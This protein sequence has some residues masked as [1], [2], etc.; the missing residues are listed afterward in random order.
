MRPGGTGDD[1]LL[2]EIVVGFPSMV[3]L[4]EQMRVSFFGSDAG[5]SGETHTAEVKLTVREAGEGVEVPMDLPVRPTCPVC[6]GRGEVWP[7]TCGMCAGTGGG[8]L[9]HQFQL[10]VPAGVRHGTRLTYC[11]TPP[12]ASETQLEVRIAIS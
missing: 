12:F 4:V 3:G 8:L 9:S 11:V 6:G 2:D 1:W 10:R 5:G 7:E